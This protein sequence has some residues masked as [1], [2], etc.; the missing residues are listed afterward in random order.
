MAKSD[1]RE[2]LKQLSADIVALKL[3]AQYCHFNV[4]G[5]SFMEYH[6]LFQ[7]FYEELEEYFDLVGEQ[8]RILDGTS[9]SSAREIAERTK[10]TEFS[11]EKDYTQ[12]EMFESLVEDNNQVREDL[13]EYQS[14]ADEENNEALLDVY[15]EIN[16]T[17]DQY[18]YF[19]NSYLE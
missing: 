1:M 4:V 7:D 12:E 2:D 3:N 17:L 14:R 5:D 19:L 15:V 9:L 8:I 10:L 16:R 6:Q 18:Y 11:S 13:S